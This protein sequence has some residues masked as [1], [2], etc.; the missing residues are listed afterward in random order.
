MSL[1]V[2]SKAELTVGIEPVL[3]D[4]LSLFKGIEKLLVNKQISTETQ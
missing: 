1:F 2:P 4:T 3:K